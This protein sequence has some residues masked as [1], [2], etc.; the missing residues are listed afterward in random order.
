MSTPFS[1]A[2]KDEYDRIIRYELEM[3]RYVRDIIG[4]TDDTKRVYEVLCR[5]LQAGESRLL[6]DLGEGKTP[7][8]VK[9]TEA[10]FRERVGE[11]A[12]LRWL[13]SAVKRMIRR[14]EEADEEERKKNTP[15]S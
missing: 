7:D 12:G 14:A 1:Q 8:G 3:S 11:V 4:K 6:L 5:I 9:Y 15:A 13:E 2:K 10:D